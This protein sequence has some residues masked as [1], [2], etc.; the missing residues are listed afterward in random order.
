MTRRLRK[1]PITDEVK[2]AVAEYVRVGLSVAEAGQALSLDAGLID[3]AIKADPAFRD[4]V[5][6]SRIGSKAELLRKISE[7]KDTD[8]ARYLLDVVHGVKPT[9]PDTYDAAEV[10][11]QSFQ[12]TRIALEFVPIDR[13]NEFRQALYAFLDTPRPRRR[14]PGRGN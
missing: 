14:K 2:T 8:D 3:Q 9:K 13:R 6:A 11:E 7:S 4:A 1:R 5:A 10:R 12:I